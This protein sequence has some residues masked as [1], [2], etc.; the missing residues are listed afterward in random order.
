MLTEFEAQLLDQLIDRRGLEDV[1]PAEGT[2]D[3]ALFG[4][5]LDL[6]S[7]DALELELMIFQDHEIE[8]IPSERTG[9]TFATLGVLAD[10]IQANLGRDRRASAAA[11]N[12]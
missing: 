1:D 3:T 2:R 10:F 8:I 12:S 6:D 11:S 7:I 5:G 4:E 9:S